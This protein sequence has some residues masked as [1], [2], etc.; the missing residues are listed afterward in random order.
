[1]KYIM[2]TDFDN[3]WDKIEG[4]FTSY[5]SN[6]IKPRM[7]KDKLVSGTPTLFIKKTK[8]STEVEKA[9]SGKVWDVNN[10]SG[11]IFFRVDIEKDIECPEEYALM[12]NGWYIES[13]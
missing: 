5:S 3:H 10:L 7:T 13:D 4:N 8:Y 6:M 1:M 9:W 12:D 11:K 2:V